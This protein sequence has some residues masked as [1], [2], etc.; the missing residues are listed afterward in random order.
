MILTPYIPPDI[1]KEKQFFLDHDLMLSAYRA[2]AIASNGK[3]LDTYTTELVQQ[4]FDGFQSDKYTNEDMDRGNEYEPLAADFYEKINNVKLQTSPFI[5]CGE[6]W[7]V[8]PDR[9]VSDDGLVEIK[10]VNDRKFEDIKNGLEKPESK[11][12]WQTQMQLLATGRKWNDLFY[13]NRQVV[14]GKVVEDYVVFRQF[15][16]NDRFEKLEEGIR[17]GT[18]LIKQKLSTTKS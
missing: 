4:H 10:V 8:S 16:D 12:L 18:E 2:Q 14:D 9:L 5:K 1:E 11:Y 7:G 3:G 17:R 13:Y 6:H 15:P